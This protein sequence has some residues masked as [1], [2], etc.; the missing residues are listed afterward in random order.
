MK[1][2]FQGIKY[3]AHNKEHL[4]QKLKLKITP[5]NKAMIVKVKILKEKI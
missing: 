3:S 4:L 5:R 1:Y 2:F